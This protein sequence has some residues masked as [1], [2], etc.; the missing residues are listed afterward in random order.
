MFYF[1]LV[2]VDW[3]L[4][5]LFHCVCL[6][7]CMFTLSVKHQNSGRWSLDAFTE[8]LLLIPRQLLCSVAHAAALKHSFVWHDAGLQQGHS[9]L[10]GYFY[11]GAGVNGATW[12]VWSWF[13]VRPR[14]VPNLILSIILAVA[15]P[16]SQ[17]SGWLSSDL[18]QT[19]SCSSVK[20][21][22]CVISNLCNLSLFTVMMGGWFFFC[23]RVCVLLFQHR[24]Y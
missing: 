15:G 13:P 6:L 22:G 3:H 12:A 17:L 11:T 7:L 2:A 8:C 23:F 5:L 18:R 4:S 24:N 21:W 10:S 9:L 16:K 1:L 20:L 14:L 19:I